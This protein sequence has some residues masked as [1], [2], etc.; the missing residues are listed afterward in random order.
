MAPTLLDMAQIFGFRPH[1]RP[2]DAVGDYHR[3]KNQHKLAKPFIISPALINQNCSFSNYLRKF[4]VEKDKDQQHM[5]F[6]LYWLNRFILPN[7]SSAVLLEYRHLVD[8]LHNHTDVGLGPSVMA[9]LFKNLHT[10]TL[11]NP[12][13]LSAPELRFPDIVLPEDQVLAQPL[14]LVEVP[15]RSIEEYLMFFKHCT[16]RSAAQW[17]VVIRRTYPWFQPGYRLFEKEPEE[18]AA[19]IDFKKKFLSVTLPRDLPHGGGKPPNYHIGAEVYHPNF[20]ARQLGC[21]Q[22]IPLKSYRSC[23]R[24]SS[25]RDLDDLEVRKDARCAVNKINNNADALYPS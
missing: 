21:P 20:C 24:A 22:L 3:K 18:E 11:E 8:A 15:K 10:A 14:M 7:R 13:N 12:L 5:L 23:N 4:S 16:K 17:Q 1:G 9:H 6:L 19:R 2:V 25:W